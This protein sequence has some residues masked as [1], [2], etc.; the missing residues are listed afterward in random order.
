MDEAYKY[1]MQMNE[2]EK[3]SV[4]VNQLEST[5][6]YEAYCYLLV[7]TL[8]KLKQQFVIQNTQNLKSKRFEKIWKRVTNRCSPFTMPL[9][10]CKRK[11][12]VLKLMMMVCKSK[13]LLFSTNTQFST[14]LFLNNIWNVSIRF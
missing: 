6:E 2:V 14:Q 10:S 12:L 5:K 8:E 4:E 1:L 3:K 11:F 13:I 7:F 9:F